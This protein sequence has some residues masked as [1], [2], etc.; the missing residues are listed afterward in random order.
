MFLKIHNVKRDAREET[1]T[2]ERDEGRRKKPKEAKVENV[3]KLL[4]TNWLLITLSECVCVFAEECVNALM[5]SLM[6]IMTVLQEQDISREEPLSNCET[7]S[8][9]FKMLFQ[10]RPED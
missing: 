10:K 2:N 4:R 8:E 7:A 1:K 5:R 3:T 6:R 9:L